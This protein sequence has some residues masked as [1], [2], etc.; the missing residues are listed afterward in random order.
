LTIAWPATVTV[1]TVSLPPATER[2]KAAA[3][4]SRQMFTLLY[5]SRVNHS[6][7]RSFMQ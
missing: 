4:E 2:T 6:W 1:G 5:R 7:V 3:P